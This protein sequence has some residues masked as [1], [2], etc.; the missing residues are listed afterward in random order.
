[1]IFMLSILPASRRADP[2]VKC[3]G[4]ALLRAVECAATVEQVRARVTAAWG[5]F[6]DGNAD[7]PAAEPSYMQMDILENR[8]PPVFKDAER[9]GALGENVL[10]TR[11]VRDAG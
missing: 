4:G 6:R 1:M 3:P 10:V 8:K 2:V 7:G 5:R 11:K 9:A